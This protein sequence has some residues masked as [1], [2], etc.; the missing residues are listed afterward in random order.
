MT[1]TADPGVVGA[2]PNVVLVHC[3]DLGNRLGCYG[4]DVQ[5]PNIDAL[6]ADGALFENHFVTA[7][8]CSPSRASLLTGLYPHTNGM[9]G[10][11]H[12]AWELNE[13]ATTL[14]ECLAAA[15]YETHLFGLQH[16]TDDPTDIGIEY[17]HSEGN[18]LPASSP[19]IHEVNRAHDVTDTVEAF[20]TKDSYQEPF[21]ATIGFF[22]LH[23]I[24]VNDQFGFNDGEYETGDPEAVAV[25]PYLPDCDGIRDDLAELEG[26]L[27]ALDEAMG[28]LT[29]ALDEAGLAEETILVFTTEH[30]IAFP[31]AKGCC[32]DPGIEATLLIRY[33]GVID[34]DSR[35]DELVSNVDVLPTILDFVDDAR[36]DD[37]GNVRPD[38]VDGRSFFPLLTD[39]KHVPR[40]QVFAEMTWHDRYNPMRSIRTPEYKYIRNFWHLPSVYLSNDVFVSKAGRAIREEFHS[41]HRPYEELYDLT[42]DPHEQTNVVDE[43]E[44]SHVREELEHRLV[45]WMEQTNDPLL[46]GPVPPGDYD[47]IVPWGDAEPNLEF[48]V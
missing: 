43:E 10:L 24:E 44:Y 39:R 27:T 7:P 36:P 32:Y 13:D 8:Q 37:L 11:A 38:S 2:S 41:G 19:E 42:D 33:P 17:V 22:E 15:G 40:E 34:S 5:T 28:R 30:G 18:L 46:D 3:H 21:F 6:A 31:R 4:R 47:A 23:R 16:V 1:D 45:S 29:G 14:P 48:D 25:P 9:M 26:M 20:L 35:Y 12:G